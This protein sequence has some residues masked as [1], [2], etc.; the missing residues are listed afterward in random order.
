[1]HS[2]RIKAHWS[3]RQSKD[4]NR[5][6]T[7]ILRKTSRERKYHQIM[8]RNKQLNEKTRYKQNIND[9]RQKAGIQNL[10]FV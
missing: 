1:M 8:K 4:T 10:T 3:K 5:K 9:K 7:R 6:H 2:G